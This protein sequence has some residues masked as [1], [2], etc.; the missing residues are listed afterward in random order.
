MS[1]TIN[2]K[3]SDIRIPILL[4]GYCRPIEFERIINQVESLPLRDVYVSL[5]GPK[6]GAHFLT[7]EV[8]SIAQK[9]QLESKHRITV[10]RSETN[11]GLLSHFVLALE[12]FF[13]RYD[14]GLILEDDMEF[15]A[16]FVE[17]LD[18]MEGKEALVNYWSV[19]GYN[20][21]KESDLHLYNH[22]KNIYFFETSVHTIW[23]WAT[24]KSSVD[25]FLDF[26]NRSAQ[27]SV[28]LHKGVYSFAR[29]LTRDIIFG[30]A[31][32][33]NWSGKIERAT[34]SQKPNWDNYW[35][36]AG[37]SA[38]KFSLMPNYSLSRENPEIFGTQ[39]HHHVPR[40]K[41]WDNIP[42]LMILGKVLKRRKNRD[43]K[44]VAVWG[45]TR[46]RAYKSVIRQ[47]LLWRGPK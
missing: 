36:L 41:P 5:D 17:F 47:R 35:V 32:I 33:K 9:W 1:F 25:F 38:K 22:K 23:G 11:L 46:M 14:Y 16:E 37:W 6:E 21:S 8:L 4:I 3:E 13:A 40:G 24:S 34:N 30:S 20:P 31:I 42:N 15:R 12:S 28:I 10:S 39:T 18:S 45:N 2:E 29:C 27:N 43:R 26:V 7:T 44:L 19:C